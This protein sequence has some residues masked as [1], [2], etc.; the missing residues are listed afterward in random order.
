MGRR[1]LMAGGAH[2][3]FLRIL[4]AR[5]KLAA[6]ENT[7]RPLGSR[8]GLIRRPLDGMAINMPWSLWFELNPPP[9]QGAGGAFNCLTSIL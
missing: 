1:G 8:Q 4:I 2:Y 6:P 3:L 9:D 5:F 7:R